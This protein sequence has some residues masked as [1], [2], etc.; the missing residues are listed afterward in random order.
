MENQSITIKKLHLIIIIVVSILVGSL[1]T[2][3]ITKINN[4]SVGD[5]DLFDGLTVYARG[6]TSEGT[7]YLSNSYMEKDYDS[8]DSEL[9]KFCYEMTIVK[10]KY[11]ISLIFVFRLFVFF[12]L[13]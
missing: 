11:H 4:N 1:G 9:S 7:L 5:V 13:F 6:T 3:L 2:V 12:I 8:T 10:W